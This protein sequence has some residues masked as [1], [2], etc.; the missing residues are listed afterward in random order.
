MSKRLTTTERRMYEQFNDDHRWCWAC[1]TL[2]IFKS[3]GIDYPRWL[4]RHHI[5]RGPARVP[6]RRVIAM[7]CKMCHDLSGGATIRGDGKPLPHLELKHV[8]WLKSRHDGPVDRPYLRSLLQRP[9][10]PSPII[11]PRF[12]QR[13][14]A[15]NHEGG[16]PAAKARHVA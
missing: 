4:E 12:F 2:G 10:L 14:Y 16:Y 9:F 11:P 8:L 6:D 5:V 1:G 13:L 15:A 3:D 7:L